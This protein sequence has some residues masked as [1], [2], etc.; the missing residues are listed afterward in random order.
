MDLLMYGPAIFAGIIGSRY[1]SRLANFCL[2]IV[3]FQ[4][5][6]AILFGQ[7]TA[8]VFTPYTVICIIPALAGIVGDR[9]LSKCK[10]DLPD[11]HRYFLI[12][13]LANALLIVAV[14]YVGGILLAFYN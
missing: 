5:D 7:L 13:T 8:A 3:V 6:L 11:R 12:G 9:Y 14:F 10:Y 1:L 4:L 2:M